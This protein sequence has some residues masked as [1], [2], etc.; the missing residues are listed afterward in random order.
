MSGAKRMLLVSG[1]Y[2]GSYRLD[3]TEI[4]NP[5]LGSWRA[6]AALPSPR[7]G[8]RAVNIDNRVLLFGGSD[9]SHLD[10][11]LEY[12]INGDSYTQLGTMIHARERHAISVVKYQDFSEWC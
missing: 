6:G 10:T 8:L 9:G 12:D 5:S 1:G 2:D 3:S 11:I 7:D 4:F